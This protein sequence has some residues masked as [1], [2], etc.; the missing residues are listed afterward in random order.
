MKTKGIR[1]EDIVLAFL[2]QDK[3]AEPLE[4]VKQICFETTAFL[5][6]YY[7][8]TLAKTDIENAVQIITG[9]LSRCPAKDKLIDRLRRGGT[10]YLP[11]SK[12]ITEIS[13]K[14]QSYADQLKKHNLN[15]DM[16][17]KELEYCLQAIRGL[18]RDSVQKHSKYIRDLLRF[19]FSRHYGTAVGSVADN[20]RRAICWVDE[21]L[22]K[23][24]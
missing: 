2:N 1:I 6:I 18:S 17:G 21:A 14:K 16:T 11:I 13:T 7:F 12:S 3:V 9:T 23:E 5:P 8:I 4:F 19:L 24:S 20:L 15:R 10:Q 22:Y